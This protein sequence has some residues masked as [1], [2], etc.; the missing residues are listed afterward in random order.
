MSELKR[1]YGKLPEPRFTPE[2]AA[3]IREGRVFSLQHVL[4][5]GIPVF[6]GHAPF[7]MRPYL[8][9]GETDGMLEGDAGFATEMTIMGQ[10]TGTHI[11]ALCHFS[12]NKE[13]KRFYYGDRPVEGSQNHD[14]ISE[15]SMEQMPPLVTRGVLLDIAELKG[16][17]VLGDSEP[18]TK[19]DILACERKQGVAIRPGDSVLLRTGFSQYWRTD[20]DRF[21]TKHAG[22][23]LSAARYMVE[24]GAV[25]VGADTS[26]FEVI[27]S[28]EHLVH[29]YLLVEQGVPILECLDLETLA[30]E[31][32]YEFVFIVTPLKLKGATASIVHPIAIR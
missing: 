30:K 27:P 1:N 25:A 15:W 18:I 20:N 17:D 10:H 19:E 16:T 28:P 29:I 22:A 3:L 2:L 21:L 8:R 26:T 12:V 9:H 6:G 11:D 23:D 7:A 24:Q 32:I 14:G 4:E 31:K 5:P 13:G